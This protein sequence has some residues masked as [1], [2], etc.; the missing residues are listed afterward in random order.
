[1]VS[2]HTLQL[3]FIGGLLIGSA[4]LLLYAASGRIAGISGITYAALWG[5][6]AQRGWRLVFLVSLVTGGWLAV[7]GGIALPTSLWPET[8]KARILLIVAGLLVGLGTQLGNGCT[9]GHGICGLA[10]L[11]ARSLAAVVVFMVFGVVAANL[12][13]PL[14]F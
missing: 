4:A 7:Q 10:R 3:P 14:W 5:E 2:I 12:L 6:R 13:R 9:S 1:M 11:S 8:N